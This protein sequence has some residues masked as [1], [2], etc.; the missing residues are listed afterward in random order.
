MRWLL[1]RARLALIQGQNF[2]IALTNLRKLTRREPVSELQLFPPA[3]GRQAFLMLPLNVE[4][5]IRYRKGTK[6][7][8]VIRS[9][10]KTKV[11]MRTIRSITGCDRWTSSLLPEN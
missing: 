9:L 11:R 7:T 6:V 5:R 8:F 1:L 3:R 4:Q 10:V 2:A